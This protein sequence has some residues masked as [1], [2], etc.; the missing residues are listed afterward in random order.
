MGANS[1]GVSSGL[2]STLAR[3]KVAP[4]LLMIVM[5]LLG[6]IA[7]MKINVQFFPSLNIS[8]V[9]VQ[10]TWPGA[11]AQDVETSITTPIERALRNLD[12]VI[13]IT[14]NA[15]NGATAIGIKFE[16]GTNMVEATDLVRQKVEHLRSLPEDSEKPNITRAVFY[17]GVARLLI[18]S[19]GGDL[20]ELRSLANRYEIELLD[21]G[22]DKISFNGLPDKEMSI[23]LPQHMLEI[24][25]L[26][27]GDITEQ[28]RNMSKDL[29]AGS[30]GDD[31]GVRDV[32]ATQQAKTVTDYS[33]I[34][35]V[36][37][38]NEKV[39][40]GDIAQINLKPKSY[41]PFIL[42]D[43]KPA[44]EMVLQRSEAGDTIKSADILHKWLEKTKQDLPTG[45]S[46]KVYDEVWSLISG[47]IKLLV[48]NGLGGLLLVVI[49]LFIFMN[50]RVAFWVAV[51]IPASFSATLMILYL[52][53][54]SI[55][56]ITMFALIM[57][58][59]IVVDD[60]IVVGEDALAHYE[61]GESAERASIGGA[62][63]M[64]ALVS[65]SSLTTIAAFVPLMMIGEEIGKMLFA[66]P[67]VM[68]AVILASLFESF[69]V[70]PGHLNHA[71]SGVKQVKKDS[72]RYKIDHAIDYFR[73]HQ[74]RRLIKLALRNRTITVMSAL[75]MFV[76][77][78]ALIV[79]GR[80][81]FV[82]FP[83]PD[84]TI[85]NADVKFVA[86][87]PEKVSQAYIDKLHKALLETEQELE[88]GILETSVVR[89]NSSGMRSGAGYGGITI[90][91]TEPDHRKTTNSEFIRMWQQKAGTA[92]GLD[93]LAIK[94]PVAGPP[95]SDVD[96][97]MWGV[98][99]EKL[100]KASLELQQALISVKGVSAIEDDLPYGREQLVYELTT[101]GYALG[102]SYASVA[103]QLRNAFASNR[104]QFFN[105]DYEEIEVR[106]QLLEEEQSTLSIIE[107]LQ[108]VTNKGER[109]PLNTVVSWTVK[110][111]FDSIR[112][113]DGRLSISVTAD[114]DKVLNNPNIILNK[115]E[116]TVMPVLENKYGISY[117]FE[118]QSANQANT[119]EDMKI[120]LI[121]GLAGIYIIL[122]WV[123]AS[124]GWPLIVMASIPFG[125]I[126]AV[127]GHW[128]MGLDLTLLSIFG[129]FGLSGIVVNDTIILVSF[130]KRL[131]A[132]GMATN[133]ALEEA[134]V[135]RLRAVM[136]T[137]LTTIAGLTPL[138]FETSLQA[139]FLIP[140][141]TSIAFGLLF[142]TLLI[143]LVIPSFL[144][145]YEEKW[146]KS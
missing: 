19:E 55:N 11:N 29:P 58:L 34:P 59:G 68:V 42:V 123:F 124:Y 132:E 138:L 125:L 143:L 26:T 62:N 51:G 64:F 92:A 41:A 133:K 50:G 94:A 145:V 113:L 72:I 95:G 139:Q 120:G 44:I 54:G 60:A 142:S 49:I 85:L 56:M 27:L 99:T 81:G 5:L 98:S 47:R 46:L 8:Y 24:Y 117:S 129:F 15:E 96:I 48:N 70:L 101:E 130:Y 79:N 31:G 61:M 63:R 45:I 32:R 109:V 14:S 97:R 67:M 121:I 128:W 37:S 36:V 118:G 84:S 119:F 30:I 53:G 88:P 75:A 111:G 107:R 105:D 2:I 135:Q 76:F 69:A 127:L 73:N 140:M 20:K 3:H 116:K 52:F 82:F 39:F 65:A 12:K 1:N 66:I 131:K 108:L 78:I 25:E 91:L 9:R 141:A 77:V 89:Y 38:E 126:G 146:V 83:S 10:V 4:N 23:Q 86:G 7:L 110:Q 112:H 102:F 33:K 93:V 104:V 115:L 16:E 87:T 43:G 40:L 6:Y 90:E 21:A 18:I 100:K 122:A 13:E 136:L 71:F 134:S 28:I 57:A 144:S 35:V 137:S 74:F 17:E 103:K 22:V 114:V 80:V 106:I